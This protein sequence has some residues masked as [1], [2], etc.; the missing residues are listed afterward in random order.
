MNCLAVFSVVSQYQEMLL[1]A[2]LLNPKFGTICC[3]NGS[4]KTACLSSCFTNLLLDRTVGCS[5][6]KQ[7]L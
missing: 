6:A 3:V 5:A 1:I 4:E 2:R 7:S